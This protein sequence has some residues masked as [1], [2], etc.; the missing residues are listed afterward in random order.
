MKP[1]YVVL[2]CSDG[3]YTKSDATSWRSI[4]QTTILTSGLK[5]LNSRAMGTFFSNTSY[6]FVVQLDLGY[7]I[8][9][10]GRFYPVNHGP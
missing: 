5:L 1:K 2:L 10:K 6:M 9:V 8:F 3:Q 4:L 7:D